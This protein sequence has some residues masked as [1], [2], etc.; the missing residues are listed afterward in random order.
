MLNL[1]A[2]SRASPLPQE[3]SMSELPGIHLA[4]AHCIIGFFPYPL[5]IDVSAVI[6]IHGDGTF[7]VR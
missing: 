4:I 7:V 5:P 2:A 1:L 3:M 6:L